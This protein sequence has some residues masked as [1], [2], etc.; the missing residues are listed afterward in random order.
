MCSRELTYVAATN[1]RTSNI[2][3]EGVTSAEKLYFMRDA[4]KVGANA[5]YR[6][7]EVKVSRIDGMAARRR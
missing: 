1:S 2:V 4:L 3:V 6:I 5:Q 7:K